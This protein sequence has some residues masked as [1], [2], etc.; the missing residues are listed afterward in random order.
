MRHRRR[1]SGELSR[2]S[3][4]F[5][6]RRR[7]KYSLNRGAKIQAKAGS[8][9][10][11]VMIYPCIDACEA[12][13]Q[14]DGQRYLLDK[15]PDLPLPGCDTRKCT[16]HYQNFV[17]RREGGDRR[18]KLAQFNAIDSRLGGEELRSDKQGDRRKSAEETEVR[19]YFND[20]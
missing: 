19:A 18:F 6:L 3:V 5:G 12:A 13:A 20:Y 8:K 11:C 7:R 17:D 2:G 10:Q 15:V 4:V 14:Q 9:Y 16:C 1:L